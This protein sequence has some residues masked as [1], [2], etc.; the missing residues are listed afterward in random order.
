MA[1]N[2]K[3]QQCLT[4]WRASR[5]HRTRRDSRSGVL[6]LVVLSMLV[7]FMLI[8]TAFLMSS[9]QEQKTAKNLSKVDR[10]G[11]YGTKL[12]DRALL[13]IVRDTSNPYSVVRY[14]S[15]LRDLYGTDGFQ[16]VI[17][18]PGTR[19]LSTAEGQVTRFAGAPTDTPAQQMGPTNGQFIDIYVSQ[20]PYNAI[21][22]S[23][24]YNPATNPLDLKNVLKLDRN[25][26][27]QPQPYPLPPTKGYFNGCLLTIT[28][29][30]AAGQSTRILDY[31]YIGPDLFA[32]NTKNPQ[33]S[34]SRLF[35]FRVMAFPRKD[36]QSL[37]VDPT[38]GPKGRSPE[39]SDLAGQTFIVNGRAFSGTGV[40]YNPLA[41]TGQP[42][43]SA[44]Q[45]FPVDQ[46]GN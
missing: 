32:G 27:G 26:Y 14:H 41:Q 19:D 35:R 9:S 16:A 7:L 13:Q 34:A 25:P 30:P 31:E 23:V 46:K 36:G 17:Y 24:S 8:G 2:Q 15:L 21:D 28:S 42:R 12:L 20:K 10:V 40:G 43:L 29:G 11:N 39:L 37:V 18:R 5:S 33:T 1:T 38:T 45:L 4:G 44:L 22:Y 3:W 6:L